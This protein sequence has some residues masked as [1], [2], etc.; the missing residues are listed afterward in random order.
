MFNTLKQFWCNALVLHVL[1][2]I[3]LRMTLHVNFGSMC[4]Y[5]SSVFLLYF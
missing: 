2:L 3:D 4:C 5:V 1:M